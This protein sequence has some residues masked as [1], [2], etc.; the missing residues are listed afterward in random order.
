MNEWV[1]RMQRR[2]IEI[3][4]AKE[5]VKVMGRESEEGEGGTESV[6]WFVWLTIQKCRIERVRIRFSGHTNSM[7]R[8]GS[9]GP[10]D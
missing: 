10:F 4:D 9:K 3:G 2:R 5:M 7:P 1:L 6:G 8:S